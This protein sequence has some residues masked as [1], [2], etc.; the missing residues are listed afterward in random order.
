MSANKVVQLQV[1]MTRPAP[2][3][4]QADLFGDTNPTGRYFCFLNIDE[5]DQDTLLKVIARNSVHTVVDLRKLPLFDK[6]KFS[7]RSVMTHFRQHG[8]LYLEYAMAVRS[9]SIFSDL[10]RD[11]QEPLGLSLWIYDEST[12]A[13]GWYD[14]VRK[15]LKNTPLFDAEVPFRTLERRP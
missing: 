13:V 12:R 1:R 3:T 2:S 8:I 11:E 7:H 10:H 4:Y 5:V 14:H 15:G 9:P 6:P